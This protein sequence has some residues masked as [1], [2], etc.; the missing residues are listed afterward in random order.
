MT[1]P[2]TETPRETRYPCCVH[3]VAG[4]KPE[5]HAFPCSRCGQQKGV[6]K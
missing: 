5:G 3:C 2:A 6:A 4:Y 1:T